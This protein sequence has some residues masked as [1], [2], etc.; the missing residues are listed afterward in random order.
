M[1]ICILACVLLI[2]IKTNNCVAHNKFDQVIYSSSKLTRLTTATGFSYFD[3]KVARKVCTEAMGN[4]RITDDELVAI[5]GNKQFLYRNGDYTGAREVIKV[6]GILRHLLKIPISTATGTTD[7]AILRINHTTTE[8]YFVAV[9]L[10]GLTFVS[11][12]TNDHAIFK[13]SVRV[14]LGLQGYGKATADA[15]AVVTKIAANAAA[16]T[17]SFGV[18][19]ATPFQVITDTTVTAVVATTAAITNTTCNRATTS[20][21]AQA[22]VVNT[23]FWFAGASKLLTTEVASITLGACV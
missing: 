5:N 13:F 12:V 7:P 16:A 17:D 8:G 22:A 18:G 15:A 19:I 20:A 14:C 11:S 10:S 1:K 3:I 23:A 4:C 6:G 9:I 2:M 21:G